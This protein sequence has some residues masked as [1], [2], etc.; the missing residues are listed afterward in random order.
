MGVLSVFYFIGFPLWLI[1]PVS[2]LVLFFQYYRAVR[3]PVAGVDS[4]E[5][6]HETHPEL[7]TV[8]SSVVSEFTISSPRVIVAELDEPNAF[9]GGRRGNGYIVLSAQL[10]QLLTVDEVAG[11]VAHEAAHLQNRDSIV[12]VFA[13]KTFSTITA[14]F[15]WFILYLHGNRVPRSAVSYT[16][17]QMMSRFL[18]LG[19]FSMSRYREYVADA[20]A[21]ERLGETSTVKSALQKLYQYQNTSV[22]PEKAI[23]CIRGISSGWFSTH[24]SLDE[25]IRRLDEMDVHE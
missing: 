10:L 3:N 21:A 25:R 2:I 1:L 14:G 13:N 23:L 17:T 16:L 11:V 22:T 4:V 9:A 18:L 7:H 5:V 15:E 19:V 20:T 6:T 12:M 24:P 8:V